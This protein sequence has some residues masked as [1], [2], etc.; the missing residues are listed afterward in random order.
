[1]NKN[2]P[3]NYEAYASWR[4][5]DVYYRTN[6]QGSEAYVIRIIETNPT[7]IRIICQLDH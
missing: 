1:M 2:T 7:N 5:V 6:S 4:G 3:N